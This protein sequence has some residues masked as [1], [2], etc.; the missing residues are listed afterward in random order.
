M[1][2]GIKPQAPKGALTRINP[3]ALGLK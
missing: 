3:A 2:R 1:L